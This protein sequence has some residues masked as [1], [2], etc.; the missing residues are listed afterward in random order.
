MNVKESIIK[1]LAWGDKPCEHPQFDILTFSEHQFD[2]DSI[3]VTSTGKYV[4]TQCGQVLTGEEYQEILS[5]RG[6]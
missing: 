5:Q 1:K 6:Q 3:M 4:C 2:V